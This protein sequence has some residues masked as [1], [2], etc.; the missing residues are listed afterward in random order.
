M[1]TRFLTL[2]SMVNGPQTYGCENSTHNK[3]HL[4]SMERLCYGR[5]VGNENLWQL[6]LTSPRVTSNM[7]LC[8]TFIQ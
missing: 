6:L 8:C 3:H 4:N 5:I 7:F 2:K 1:M